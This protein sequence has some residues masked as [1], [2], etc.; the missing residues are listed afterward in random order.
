MRYTLK[1]YQTE[2]VRDVLGNLTRA[3]EMYKR[4]GDCSQFSLSAT[5]GAGKTVMATAIIEAL[6]F[7][8]DEFDFEA[9]PGAV[10]L[11]FSDDPSL[12]EQSRIRIQTA[13]SELD[14]RLRVI[15]PPFAETSLRP[16][17]VYFLNTQKLSKNSLLVRSDRDFSEDDE[18]LF[19]IAPDMLQASI[20]DVLAN[21]INNEDLTLYMILDE[22]HRGMKPVK[23]RTT[24]VQR[25]INGKNTT[26]AIPIVL[27][28]SATVE[29]FNDAMN[30]AIKRIAL[31]PVEV[32][33]QLVQ[34]SG[35][36]KDDIILS[37][38]AESG[39]FDTVLLKR[40]VE[41]LKVSAKN[42]KRY[43]DK[44]EDIEDVVPLLVIQMGDKPDESELVR[45]LDTIFNTDPDLPLD[46]VANV[47]GE[48]QDITAGVYTIPYIEPQNVQDANWCRV[49]L[50]KTAISTGWDC[51]RAEVLVSFRPASDPTHITQLLGRMIRTPLARRIPGNEVLNSVS[52]LL[53]F[54]DKP[55]AMNVADHLMSGATGSDSDTGGGLGRRVLFNPVLLSQNPAIPAEVWDKFSLLPTTTVPKGKAKPIK[56]LT[57][58]AVALSKDKIRPNALDEALKKLCFALDGKAL[59]YRDEVAKARDDV[60]TLSGEE[61]RK[62][63]ATGLWQEK[64]F[65][66]AVDLRAIDTSYRF[67]SRALSPTLANA[68]VQHL[69]PIGSD[70]DELLEAQI[71]TSALALVPEIVADIEIEADRLSHTWLQESRIAR[72][73]LTDLQQAEYDRL[74]GMSLSPELISLVVPEHAQ[75]DTKVREAD[76][77]ELDLPI[78]KDHLLVDENGNYPLDLNDWE[79]KVLTTEK[80]RDAFVGW[81][82]NPD[83]AVKESMAIA[84]QE[85]DKWKALRPDFIFFTKTPNGI[86]ADI[87]DPHGYH[88]ADALPKL[89]GLA[90]FTEEHGQHFRRIEAVAEVNG[91]LRVLDIQREDTRSAIDNAQDVKGLY[92]SNVAFDY[93]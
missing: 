52:C 38:P 66:S 82:R 19:K 90:R 7:G 2:A 51:P 78:D 92:S 87:V 4:F 13:G 9:D 67:A 58:L 18:A 77:S 14:S 35:L 85:N 72:K 48:H 40:A 50:A 57:L 3:K 25:L 88:L 75:A 20:Y 60:E 81:Y 42:W 73:D 39:T 54:F 12:N 84:Y 10:V 27:G 91:T 56:R 15:E 61:L 33:S 80:A 65:D 34:A 5:T 86:V 24:I 28:I 30:G 29:R 76:G 89:R 46:C 47:F 26:P 1:D 63:M 93:Q 79:T 83:R 71:I 22:A 8:S 6:F 41:Q 62:D 55:T 59:Q 32:D 70:N 68:Y 36:L 37:I 17:N 16:G 11:W 43:T 31:P 45:T 44:Q 64:A 23:D 49:L 21:T 69:A 53:P 74:E